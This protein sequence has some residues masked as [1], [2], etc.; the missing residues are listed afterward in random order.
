MAIASPPAMSLPSGTV[1][2]VM[3][4]PR[5]MRSCTARISS[6]VALLGKRSFGS[7]VKSGNSTSRAKLPR[8]I[9]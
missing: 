5:E 6:P 1:A 3:S 7:A 4:R 2:A 9:S 8:S